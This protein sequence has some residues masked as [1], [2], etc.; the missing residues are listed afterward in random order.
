MRQNCLIH[1][2]CKSVARA[3]SLCVCRVILNVLGIYSVKCL[4][5]EQNQLGILVLLVLQDFSPIHLTIFAVI[6]YLKI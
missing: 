1:F 5:I 6:N 3:L 2:K 4:Q